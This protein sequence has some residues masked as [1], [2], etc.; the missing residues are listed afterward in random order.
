MVSPHILVVGSETT[1]LQAVSVLTA[2][3]S[4]SAEAAIGAEALATVE[5]SPRP[6]LILF[7]L[8]N[9]NENGLQTLRQLRFLR[10]DLKIV[11]LSPSADSRQVV[12]A[13][14]LG[15]EDYVNVPLQGT[16]LQQVLR[17]YLPIPISETVTKQPAQIIEEF[18]NG[19]FFLAASPAMR[20]VHRH[21]ELLADLDVPVLIHGEDGTGKEAVARLIHKLSS[22]SQ[23][24]FLKINCAALPDEILESELFGCERGPFTGAIPTK[25]GKL[26][27]CDKGTVLLDEVTELSANLQ[28]KLLHVL[29]DKKFFR[30][31]GE[32]MIDIEV[33]VLA[34]TTINLQQAIADGQ[35]REDLYY[36]LSAF[37]M[38]LPPLRE[39][40]EEI[41]QLL[42]HFMERMAARYSRQEVPFTP[43]LIEACLH[44]PWRGNMRELE[45]FVKRYL[46]MGDESQAL[47][48]LQAPLP[49]RHVPTPAG[50]VTNLPENGQE[51]ERNLKLQLRSLKV[52]AEIEAITKTLSETNWNRKRAARLLNISYRGL[53]YK[54]RE[55][56][57]IQQERN[58]DAAV[59]RSQDSLTKDFSGG[60]VVC[61]GVRQR[62]NR[63]N[64]S[65][66]G[67]RG[68]DVEEIDRG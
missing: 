55:H 33:R 62:P 5:H 35:F 12:E 9:G 51:Q 10:P 42:H 48:E 27:L 24:E 47:S 25:T 29:Q 46:V 3:T 64:E 40:P 21:A 39:R 63:G 34:S 50:A 45:N 57:I 7:E 66:R 49:Q 43:A 36:R 41:S 6:D 22:R 61:I 20:K 16:E 38:S 44:H 14:R 28:A 30:L 15:A 65:K 53:L 68:S 2:R 23:H 59:K 8:G 19:E 1:T 32:S 31:R 17:R 13:I 56:G 4:C 67:N 11:V 18:G 54:I 60:G 58:H 37:T 26:E 52:E